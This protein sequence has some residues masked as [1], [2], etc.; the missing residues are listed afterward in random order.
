MRAA[1]A[2]LATEARSFR[3]RYIRLM[4]TVPTIAALIAASRRS[5]RRYHV[6]AQ[7][8]RKTKPI[9]CA[10]CGYKIMWLR[11]APRAAIAPTSASSKPIRDR[12]WTPAPM[13]AASIGRC[14]SS[15]A[16]VALH[17]RSV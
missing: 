14:A 3:L 5:E 9:T 7:R 16:W 12:E 1:R 15:N 17:E 10:E 13:K 11:I 6:R 8:L 4:L 2:C